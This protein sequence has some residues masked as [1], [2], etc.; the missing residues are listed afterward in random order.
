M[1][2]YR[3]RTRALSFGLLMAGV[4]QIALAQTAS[5]AD[6]SGVETVVV[7]A[8]K[9]QE[10]AQNV[11]VS[12]TA[13]SGDEATARGIL[14]SNDLT[15]VTPALAWSESN[16]AGSPYIRG[17]GS[18]ISTAGNQSDVPVYMDGVLLISPVQY[19]FDFNNVE[20]IE[21]L[22]GPQ[23]TLFGRNAAGGVINIVTRDPVQEDSADLSLGYGNYNTLQVQAFGNAAIT[24]TLAGNLAVNYD[25][26]FDGWGKNVLT[27]KQEYRARSLSIRGK[28]D[29]SPDAKTDVILTASYDH[30]YNNSD[31]VRILQGTVGMFGGTS[32]ASFYDTNNSFNSFVRTEAT[33]VSL[34]V[35]H[36]F[37]IAT[38]KSIT[39]YTDMNSMWSYDSDGGPLVLIEGPIPQTA[40][41]LT[42][43]FQLVS[44]TDQKISWIAGLFYMQSDYAF[45]PIVLNGVNVGGVRPGGMV[46]VWG[47]TGGPS[48]AAYAQATWA[49]FPDTNLTLGGR[50]TIDDRT[51]DGHT[52]VAGVRGTE[53][54]QSTSFQQ[55]TYHV[56]LDHHFSDDVMVYTSMSDGFNSGQ[57]N[58]GNADA[59]AV[60][61]EEITAY[62]AGF[63]TQFLDHRLQINGAAYLYNF[64][65]LQVN[66]IQNAVTLQTN[67]AAAHVKGFE[68][69]VDTVPIDRLHLGLGLS[70]N[71][72]VYSNYKNAQIYVPLPTGGY[73]TT[74]GDATGNQMINAP[75]WSLTLQADY[76]FE[77]ALGAIVPN[78]NYSYKAKMFA[79]YQNSLVIPASNE[80]NASIAFDPA[81]AP[82][83][84]F[85]V[86]ARNILDE[87]TYASMD[88]RNEAAQYTPAAP[89][90]Y[91]VSLAV[92]L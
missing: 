17:V 58:T 21:V 23:G 43:E 11:P 75:L 71:D 20:R 29:W 66:I 25:N 36:D 8:E 86:W 51:V 85:R 77:T 69:E 24:D 33:S 87:K 57:F 2:S 70:Y 1:L 92:H 48:Y 64:T 14:S 56:S 38:F 6:N 19:D 15:Q 18:L 76:T 28:L 3:N 82:D 9:R 37:G 49:I 65:D 83:W 89:L 68:L 59:P 61:P 39:A 78:V 16:G 72:G 5:P 26:Q 88:I 55:P 32:P 34:R 90:T 13:I 7:T 62:E 67:A 52:D 81:S 80:L 54:Y 63:K 53:Y 47:H 31:D 22:E 50:Y 60:K 91:G 4:S 12:I 40:S 10:V 27:G 79:D 41:G 42:Q 45:T 30:S 35:A 46:D 73:T 84:E 44:P 74:S